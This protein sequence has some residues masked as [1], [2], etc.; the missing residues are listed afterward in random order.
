[1]PKTSQAPPPSAPA[2]ALIARLRRVEGQVRAVQAL[3][4]AGE[5]CEKI[6]QQL[7]AA[8]KALDRSFYEMMAC[9]LEQQLAVPQA[10]IKG[11]GKPRA[12]LIAETTRLLARYG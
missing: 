11:K 6:A 5:P 10:G 1:M 3:I 9:H 7:A 4:A 8:R 2:Q 12:A